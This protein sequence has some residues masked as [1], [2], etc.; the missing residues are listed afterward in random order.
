MR[1]VAMR[2]A[3]RP[4]VGGVVPFWVESVGCGALAET[5]CHT[6]E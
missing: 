6:R 4:S 5:W 3:R 2:L 1:M